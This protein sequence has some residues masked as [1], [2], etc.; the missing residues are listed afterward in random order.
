MITF[1]S[2]LFSEVL[3]IGAASNIDLK[4]A[5]G[6][7]FDNNCVSVNVANKGE[8][9]VEASR[10]KRNIAGVVPSLL[11]AIKPFSAGNAAQSPRHLMNQLDRLAQPQ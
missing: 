8:E 2:C 5:T 6:T 7:P 11:V 4:E 10:C 1:V 9:E 3:E